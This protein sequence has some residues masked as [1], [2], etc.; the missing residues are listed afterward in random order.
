MNIDVAKQDTN[1]QSFQYNFSINKYNLVWEIGLTTYVF[2]E[3]K[4]MESKISPL[5][6][7]LYLILV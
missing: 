4:F 6:P 1:L 5:L 2:Q 3:K 7:N